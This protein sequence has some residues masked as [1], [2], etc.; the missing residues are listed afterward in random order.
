MNCGRS[1]GTVEYPAKPR[2]S[3]AHTATT[4]AAEGLGAELAELTVYQLRLWI[5]SMTLSNPSLSLDLG[6]WAG[7]VLGRTIDISPVGS[8]H[9]PATR[10]RP[11][12][13]IR[14]PCVPTVAMP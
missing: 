9:V 3:A 6:E 8:P 4:V 11:A 2:T 1:A 5:H 12:V 13:A 14:R 10:F 7:S